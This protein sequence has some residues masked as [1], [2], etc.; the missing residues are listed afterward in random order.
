[1]DKRE[2]KEIFMDIAPGAIKVMVIVLLY[3]WFLRLIL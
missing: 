2:I 3:G 1:V